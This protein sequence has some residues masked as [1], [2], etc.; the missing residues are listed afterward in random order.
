M[1]LTRKQNDLIQEAID[2]GKNIDAIESRRFGATTAAFPKWT[3]G[4]VPYVLSPS[5][6]M[7]CLTIYYPIHLFL[8]GFCLYQM[9][10]P[11]FLTRTERCI[12]CRKSTTAVISLAFFRLIFVY[13][14]LLTVIFP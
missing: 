12:T 13:F 6:S 7:A 3:N 8:S 2:T 10:F 14:L 1:V 5:L 4:I 11:G 9:I